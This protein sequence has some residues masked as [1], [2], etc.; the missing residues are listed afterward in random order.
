MCD[1]T[2]VQGMHFSIHGRFLLP[3]LTCSASDFVLLADQVFCSLI[4][5]EFILWIHP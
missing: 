5:V 3:I 2:G 1:D 4:Y